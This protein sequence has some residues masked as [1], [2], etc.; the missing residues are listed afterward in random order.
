[1]K[2]AEYWKK[3]MEAIEDMSHDTS[4]E[5][6][7]NVEEQFQKAQADISAKIETWY[8]RLANNNGI[9]L[10]EAKKLLRADEL[11]EF[12]WTVDEYIKKGKM[13][14]Y[15]KQWQS[16]LEN[17]S[18]KVHINRL[19]AIKLQLQ[20]ECE[21]LYGNMADGLGYTLKKIYTDGY[22]HTAYE[23]Q[24]GVNVGWD[25][26][27]LDSRK[28]EQ[29]INTC[30]AADGKNFTARCWTNKDKLV[31]ELNTI[32]TQS[33]IRGDAPQ[34]AIQQLS[35]RMQVSK[36]NAGRLI[37]T[38]AAAISS[39]SQKDC[40]KELD[41]EEFEFV[42]TLDSRTSDIC[43]SMDGQHF[44]MSDYQIGVNAPP[45]HCRCRSCT[46]PYFEDELSIGKRAARGGD[47]KTYYVPSDM[48]YSDWEKSFV[49]DGNKNQA[50]KLEVPVFKDKKIQNA[51][52]EF[53]D[54]LSNSKGTDGVVDKMILYG[55]ATDFVEDTEILSAFAYAP[56]LDV[57]LYNSKVPNYELYDM[58]FVQAHELSHRMDILEFHSW[59]NQK[60]IKAVDTCR[61]RI[62]NKTDEIAEW[63]SEGG[64]YDGDMA[65]SDIVSALSEGGLN[66]ILYS[67]HAAEYWKK[68]R[69]NI[70]L[71][72]FANMASI[73]V[74][75]Y[76]SKDEFS[77]LL[78]E[79]YEAY[80]ELV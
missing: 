8:A 78:K 56:D 73:D 20:Q 51:Y 76:K 12:H 22:L 50:T 58:N 19:E 49:N 66:D 18:A 30:W 68:D 5:Y 10:S 60:F 25:L 77:G 2:N 38:E 74:L 63:F 62:Y 61:K 72:I 59:E 54:L 11:E 37:L 53:S 13:L 42:A 32:L 34:K 6:I 45:L 39:M 75:D 28:I 43:R 65:L 24:K 16:E 29:V 35:R 67:G 44:K 7:K 64:K 31:N 40:F 26:Q 79:L 55:Y 69:E 4:I 71:E 70:Y 36:S 1:M 47:G 14:K 23:I 52:Q 80:K 9:S 41:V 57:I 33:V 17:V 27:M 46:A 15:T 21:K 3:R 48:T